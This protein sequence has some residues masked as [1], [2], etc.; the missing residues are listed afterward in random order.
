MRPSHYIISVCNEIMDFKTI[1]TWNLIT[2][3]AETN[4][5]E[6]LCPDVT[7][8]TFWMDQ[9]LMQCKVLRN[10]AMGDNLFFSL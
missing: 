6:T 4:C 8:V 5:P 10:P 9:I 7:P 1:F 3:G 2:F